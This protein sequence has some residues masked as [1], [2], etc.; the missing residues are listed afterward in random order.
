L[1]IACANVANLLLAR[2]TARQREFAIRVAIGAGRARL[3]RQLVTESLLFALLGAAIGLVL[4]RLGAQ[5]LVALLGSDSLVLDL[6]LNARVLAFTTIVAVLTA[7][8]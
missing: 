5:G 3:A 1:L 2:A 4:A 6:S 7:L 8:F